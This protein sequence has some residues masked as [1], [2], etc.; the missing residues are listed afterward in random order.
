MR[1]CRRLFVVP[2]GDNE[3]GKST[4]I[5]AL[6]SQG[7]GRTMQA[8]QHGLQHLESST[9]K[10]IEALVFPRSYQESEKA[11]HGTVEIALHAVDTQW[12]RRPLVIMP[13]HLEVDDIQE[14]VRTA[15]RAG[16]DAVAAPIIIPE[17]DDLTSDIFTNS[18]AA[19]WDVRWTL[20]N[21]ESNNWDA[22]VQ[23]LGRDL[24]TWICRAV[25]Q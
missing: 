18:L 20:E 14:I 7:R 5:R 11:E 19:D 15:R 9:G 1:V 16:F 21:P 23:A 12:R 17:R 4:L 10:P 8:L 2:L 3:H 24:W 25:E 6:V 13:S 22:Q